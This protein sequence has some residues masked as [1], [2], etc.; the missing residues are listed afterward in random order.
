MLP[1]GRRGVVYARDVSSAGDPAAPVSA[2][3]SAP[4]STPTSAPVTQM[5]VTGLVEEAMTK[6]G[7]LWVEVPGDR[8]W[9]AWHAWAGGTAYLVNGP[10]EQHLPW[11]P[12]EVTLIVRSRDTGGRLLRV[13]ARTRLLTDRDE[14]WP[15]AVDALLASR[16]N[17]TGDIVER[18]RTQCAVTALTPFG[19]LV[20]GPG[21][22][23]DD[24]GAA[25]PPP[26]RATTATWR[27]WHWRGRPTRRRGS[28]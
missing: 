18:W 26:S 3:T 10:G 19:S 13:R 27:P 12:E 15:A 16:L 17:A 14:E 9:P 24:S 20:E 22:Y 1:Q 25:P 4:T 23:R 7:V 6:S 8:A 11:L 2:P 21:A 5:N 28:R